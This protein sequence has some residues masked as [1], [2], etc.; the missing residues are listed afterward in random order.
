MTVSVSVAVVWKTPGMMEKSLFM[1]DFI[2]TAQ[3]CF[4]FFDLQADKPAVLIHISDNVAAQQ[5]FA[6]PR[7]MVVAL[8]ST[9]Y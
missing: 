9:F 8:C 3:V 2:E 7:M 1:T 6:A 5:M 4:V